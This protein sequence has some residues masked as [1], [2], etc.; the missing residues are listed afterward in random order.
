MVS[1]NGRKSLYGVSLNSILVVQEKSRSLGVGA[2]AVSSARDQLRRHR[3]ASGGMVR[4][5]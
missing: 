3:T 2:A 1:I 4:N 5:T